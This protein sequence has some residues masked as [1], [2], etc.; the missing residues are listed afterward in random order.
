M[1]WRKNRL[2]VILAAVHLG[3][4]VLVV[5]GILAGNEPDWPMAWILF[6]VVDFPVS[7][8]WFALNQSLLG[9]VP[10]HLHLVS[11][12]HSPLND[13]WN[14]LVPLGFT[15]LVGTAWWFFVGLRLQRWRA[16]RP[17]GVPWWSGNLL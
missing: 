6:L 7:L 16:A 14:F 10:S 2:A 13:V 11:P 8:I 15:G 9:V 17:A 12:S 5:A 3:L 1:S 4:V